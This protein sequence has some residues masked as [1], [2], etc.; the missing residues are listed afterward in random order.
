MKSHANTQHANKKTRF[1][2]TK[3][4]GY[5]KLSDKILTGLFIFITLFLLPVVAGRFIPHLQAE[6]LHTKLESITIENGLSQNS[7]NCILQDNKG[8][9]WF[10]TQDGLNKY[11][12][13]R[14]TFYKHYMDDPNSISDNFILSIYQDKSNIIWVGTNGGGL[15]RYDPRLELWEQYTHTNQNPKSLSSNFIYV[16]YEDSEGKLWIGTD[17]G[18]NRFDRK[19][20][21]FHRYKHNPDDLQSLSDNFVYSIVEDHRGHLWIGTA[22]GLNRLD[23]ET[24]RFS[25][26]AHDPNDQRSL[27]DNTVYAICEDQRGSLWIGTAQGLNRF[28]PEKEHFTQYLHNP[29]NNHSL[30]H[31][32][33][34]TIYE[35]SR[36]TLWVGTDDGL[37]HLSRNSEKFVHYKH[38]PDD[39]NSLSNS[40]IRAIYEDRSGILWIGTF[41]G[42][43]NRISREKEKFALFRNDPNNPNSLSSNSVWSIHEDREGTIWIGT[44]HGLNKYDRD[45]GTYVHYKHDPNDISSLSQGIVRSIDEDRSGILWIGTYGGGLNRFEETEGRF[46]HYQHDPDDPNT[47]S[48]DY[49]RIVYEDRSNDLWVGTND[50]L[51]KWDRQSG[52]FV[53]YQHNFSNPHSLSNDRVR[54]IYEDKSG[55]LWI[56]TYGGLNQFDRETGQF[57]HYK[58]DP[59]SPTS[60]SNDRVSIYEDPSGFL[61][62]GTLGGGLNQFHRERKQFTHYTEKDGLPNNSVYGILGDDSGHLWISTN[63]GLSKFNPETKTFQNYD[64]HDGLQSNEFNGGAYCKTR[65]GEMFFGGV[66][67]LNSFFPDSIKADRYNP[68]VVIT[69]FHILNQRVPIGVNRDGRDIL[70]ESITETKFIQLSHKE[71]VISFEFAALHYAISDKYEYAYIMEGFDP[72]WNY[73]GN[74]RV[75]T[76]TNLSPGNYIF[77]V[78]AS[79]NGG[80]WNE[81]TTNIRIKV[82]PP[83]WKTLWFRIIFFSM[84]ILTGIS[85]YRIRTRAIQERNRM[86]EQRVEERTARLRDINEKLQQEILTRQGAEIALKIEKTYFEQLFENAPEAIVMTDDEGG[87]LRVNNEFTE[88]FGYTGEETLGHSIDELLAPEDL[89]EEASSV[90]NQVAG[91]KKVV[92][93]TIRKCKDGTSIH[94]SILGAPIIVDNELVAVY[95]IY[96]D[97]T[98]RIDNEKKQ[99][100]LMV[101]LESVNRELKDFAYIVSHDLKAPL[102]AIASLVNWLSTDYGEKFNAEGKEMITL[103]TGRVRRMNDLIDGILQYSRVGRIHEDKIKVNLN[104]LIEDVIELVAPPSNFKIEVKKKL[105]SLICEKT[106][107]E[108]VFEN[109]VANAIKYMDKPEGKISIRCTSQ[110]GH[111]KFGVTDN[112]PGIEETY[113]E[114][115]FQIF[116][117]LAPRDEIE[118]TGV[119]L[120]LVKKIVEMYGGKI[121]IES[122]V[123]AGSTFYFTWPKN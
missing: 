31:H 111:W 3:F 68:P 58:N 12:G 36:G 30:S 54:S 108:Q 78:K 100:Q 27:S 44:D 67:G 98:E 119:G 73:I 60:L 51:N 43:I 121:W 101:Q 13:Y 103:L 106:R 99:N 5:S 88:I 105:P 80:I 120:S 28:D 40:I 16:I 84:I 83:L 95:G 85:I 122:K 34:R 70:K 47:L 48:N 52:K 61:W 15:N 110:N 14:F 96:R 107:M 116:Q 93:E 45:N 91:G 8:F 11:D 82:V 24:G 22:G 1:K 37:N 55:H 113:F 35:D 53:R 42:G 104:H 76:Y 69:D 32:S 62:I 75:A 66:N 17:E 87:I 114:K 10:G 81:E 2:N 64:F 7:I 56:G 33:V 74:R 65:A 77:R 92:L 79:N 57:T 6:T 109:L 26:Y 21:A 9:M 25:H 86:L 59:K 50:G 41:G 49:I 23:R 118:S 102:R 63:N 115:I 39:L 89:K 123:G 71:K 90:T 19:T 18:L 46:I 117:T 4:E 112:G 94:V 29:H 72:D 38:N 97:I 20:K